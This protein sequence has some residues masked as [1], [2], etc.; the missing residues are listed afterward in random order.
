M[1]NWE[2]INI[3]E[4]TNYEFDKTYAKHYE[5]GSFKRLRVVKYPNNDVK[6]NVFYS[7]FKVMSLDIK[8]GIKYYYEADKFDTTMNFKKIADFF[9]I[10]QLLIIN[11]IDDL[12]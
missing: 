12:Y 5:D 7:Y 11:N 3:K 2:E 10:E 4:D 1:N 6:Y 8:T 9:K